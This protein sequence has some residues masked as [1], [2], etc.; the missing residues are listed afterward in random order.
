MTKLKNTFLLIIV[1][2]VFSSAFNSIQAQDFDGSEALA[3]VD[4]E[5]F[6]KQ[7]MKYD[8]KSYAN[9][10]EIERIA[11]AK[12]YDL[13]VTKEFGT[14]LNP[15]NGTLNIIN[16]KHYTKAQFLNKSSNENIFSIKIDTEVKTINISKYEAGEYI[17]ILSNND[18]DILVDNFIII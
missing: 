11:K 9:K 3:F 1:I 2:T 12:E 15:Y 10:S 16:T 8:S 7:N 4:L 14:Y 13:Y 6:E 5:D 17:L 18:G